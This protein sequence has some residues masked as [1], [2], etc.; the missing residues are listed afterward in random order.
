ML[1]SQREG[2]TLIIQELH[3]A[4]L[5][6]QNLHGSIQS[7][8]QD[9]IQAGGLTDGR[10]NHVESSQVFAASLNLLLCPPAFGYLGLKRLVSAEQLGGALLDSRLQ[11]V[12][13]LPKRFF[14]AL[15]LGDV[16]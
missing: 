8:I 1:S 2:V 16:L 15:A 6:I 4:T 12:M 9:L 11:L 14:G 5:Q 13:G 7:V 10:R 3:P